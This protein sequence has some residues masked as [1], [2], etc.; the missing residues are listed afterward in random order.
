MGD[1]GGAQ[2][3]GVIKDLLSDWGFDWVIC[4]RV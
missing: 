4:G 1:R 3:E 2:K